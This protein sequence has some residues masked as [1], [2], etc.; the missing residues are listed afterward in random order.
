MDIGDLQKGWHPGVVCLSVLG[1]SLHGDLAGF[2]V[3]INTGQYC[4]SVHEPKAVD[5]N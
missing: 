1:L 2:Y 3:W 5:G 4:T